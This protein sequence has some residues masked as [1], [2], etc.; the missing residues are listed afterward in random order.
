MHALL[1]CAAIAAAYVA[2][3]QLLSPRLPRNHPAVI[4]RRSLCVLGSCC[5]SWLPVALLAQVRHTMAATP[6]QGDTTH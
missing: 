6:R 5:L 2:P 3:L 4:W 1:V